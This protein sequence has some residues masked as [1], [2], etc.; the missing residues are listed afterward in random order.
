MI[1]ATLLVTVLCWA[2]SAALYCCAAL[3]KPPLG[4]GILVSF[5]AILLRRAPREWLAP[6]GAFLVGGIAPL[7]SI[8]LFFVAHDALQAARE[9]A[10]RMQCG[11]NLHQM[12]IA[13]HNY[14]DTNGTFP[15][16]TT[17]TSGASSSMSA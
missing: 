2:G 13:L 1:R 16:R 14:H 5:A 8:A 11:N 17:S 6:T 7:L 12:G 3:L 4:G 15:A 10:R 9:S